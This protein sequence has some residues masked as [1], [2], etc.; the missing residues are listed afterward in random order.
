MGWHRNVVCAVGV[1]VA[2]AGVNLRAQS[3]NTIS[4]HVMAAQ[5]AA[6]D[7]WLTVQ[8]ELCGPAQGGGGRTALLQQGQTPPAQA[9]P[10]PRERWYREP[11]KVFDNLYLFPTNDVVAWAIQTSAGIIM[12]DATYDYSVKDLIVDN[13]AKVGL[14][15]A[16]IK[17][18]VVT[19]GHADHSAGA[20]YL[21]DTF[22][23]RILL[24][25]TDWEL[26][27]QPSRGRGAGPA[28]PRKDMVITDGQKLTLGDTTITLYLTPGHTSGTVSAIIPVKDHSTPHVVAFWGGTAATVTSPYDNLVAYGAS[29]RRF[30][31]VAANAGAD[32]LLSNHER[33]ID[34]NKRLGA[35]RANPAGPNPF[36]LGAARVRSFLQV[37]DHCTQALALASASKPSTVK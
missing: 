24:S 6:G 32:V 23:A 5:A 12:I 16:Q 7:T 9:G 17:Y 30:E 8:S 28:V 36:I 33:Y 2:G 4:T 1:L 20:K 10:P 15:P 11:V 18:V 29:A 21:Q 19:H 37:L 34:L 3:S 26:L 35:M 25:A 27:A 31:T 13:M 14:D 22:G